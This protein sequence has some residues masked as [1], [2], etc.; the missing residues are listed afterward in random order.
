MKILLISPLGFAVNENLRYGGIERLVWNFASEL[1]KEHDVSVWGHSDS[2]FSPRVHVYDYRPQPADNIYFQSELRQ[3]QIYQSTLREFD[4][5]HDFSH[6][7]L[8]ARFNPNL[9]T[10]NIFW[11]APN[12]V[13]YPKSPYNII[14]LSQWACRMFE[15]YYHQKARY[16]QSIALDV[17]MYVPSGEQKSGRF[18]TIGRMAEEKGNLLAAEMCYKMEVPL[19]VCGADSDPAYK[20]RVMALCDGKQIKYLGEVSEKKKLHLMQTCQGLIYATKRPE[21]TNHKMQ[22]AMLCGAMAIM[23]PIGA[24]P[25]IITDGVNGY[26]CSTEADFYDKINKVSK[27][28]NYG[29]PANYNEFRERYSISRVVKD[30]IPLYEDVANGARW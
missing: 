22:E 23:P 1:S 11:H 25:E 9:P 26:L 24:A 12:E 29:L 10:L 18:L 21:V 6:Q 14:G 19:D 5:I 20:E 8:S 2:V 28:G 17:G 7:H 30:Y 4:V 13:Q 15:K 3:Y 16:Q 27:M